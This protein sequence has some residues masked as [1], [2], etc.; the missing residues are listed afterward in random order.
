MIESARKLGAKSGKW[1]SYTV[2][3]WGWESGLG[4]ERSKAFNLEVARRCLVNKPL[5]QLVQ[6]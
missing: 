3:E 6:L 1:I 5:L 2:I 4:G